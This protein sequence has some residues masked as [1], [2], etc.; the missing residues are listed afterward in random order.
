[1]MLTKKS[2]AT[3]ESPIARTPAPPNKGTP[4]AINSLKIDAKKKIGKNFPMFKSSFKVEVFPYSKT[5][6]FS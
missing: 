1:M 5:K 2:T 3:I 6:N 4:I